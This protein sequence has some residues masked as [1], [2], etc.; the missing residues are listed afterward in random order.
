M[1]TIHPHIQW[2][3]TFYGQSP[4]D[5]ENKKNGFAGRFSGY[6][7]SLKQPSDKIH[8]DLPVI[9]IVGDSIIGNYCIS[10]IRNKFNNIANVNFLQQPHHCKNI[11]SWLKD[12]KLEEWKHYYC[13]FWFDGMHGFPQ[14]VTEVE[15]QELT[16][17]LANRIKKVIPKILWCNC[18]PIPDDMP[19]NQSNSIRG[20]NTKEQLVINE[21]VINRNKSIELVMKNLEIHLLDIYTLIKP[22]QN[23]IQ[24]KQDL[25]FIPKG[26]ILIGGYISN[27]LLE[28]FFS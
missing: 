26:E 15:H 18:T 20:P 2:T 12:W 13:I 19:Q 24:K 9:L 6:E 27:K 10:F 22:L 28:L 23:L 21:S 11:D 25:H 16:S 1:N 14:R 3:N 8:S 5:L 17:I 7:P 4:G